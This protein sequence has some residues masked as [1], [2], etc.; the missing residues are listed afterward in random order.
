MMLRHAFEEWKCLRVELKTDALH[1]RSRHAI[2]PMGAK[3]EGTLRRQGI[4]WTGRVRDSV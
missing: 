1:P 2:L 4:S 3:E